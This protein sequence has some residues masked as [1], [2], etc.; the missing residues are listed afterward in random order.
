LKN[1]FIGNSNILEVSTLL[2]SSPSTQA[3]HRAGR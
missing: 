1:S 3:G 2:L